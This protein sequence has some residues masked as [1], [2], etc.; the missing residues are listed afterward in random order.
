MQKFTIKNFPYS[1]FVYVMKDF[2]SGLELACIDYNIETGVARICCF[3][4]FM[5]G[6]I[7]DLYQLL[8]VATLK[9]H[10]SKSSLK[11]YFAKTLFVKP[12]SWKNCTATILNFINC[13]ISLDYLKFTKRRGSQDKEGIKE[14]ALLYKKYGFPVFSGSVEVKDVKY[15]LK[16]FIEMYNKLDVLSK[17]LTFIDNTVEIEE[18]KFDDNWEPPPPGCCTPTI[19]EVE[20]DI[21]DFSFVEHTEIVQVPIKKP[22]PMKPKGYPRAIKKVDKLLKDF[23]VELIRDREIHANLP[24]PT[25]ERSSKKNLR[26]TKALAN[27]ELAFKDLVV[28]RNRYIALH[29]AEKKL[30][31]ETNE[32]I[33]SPIQF[34]EEKVILEK[35]VWV[36]KK[37]MKVTEKMSD[38]LIRIRDM[39]IDQQ[40]K[41]RLSEEELDFTTPNKAIKNQPNKKA[42]RST[43]RDDIFL[44]KID[45][46][47]DFCCAKFANECV[48]NNVELR[49]LN[50]PSGFAQ[51]VINSVSYERFLRKNQF[52][53]RGMSSNDILKIIYLRIQTMGKNVNICNQLNTSKFCPTLKKKTHWTT[54][55]KYRGLNRV[56][57]R[58]IVHPI[59]TNADEID[60]Y[61]Q[62]HR[63]HM[64]KQQVE[65]ESTNEKFRELRSEMLVRL[66]DLPLKRGLRLLFQC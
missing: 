45:V 24:P 26:L 19:L 25:D 48:N 46:I 29:E 8:E 59:E 3:Y 10:Y 16:P 44:E 22:E 39:N 66:S 62:Y 61:P 36:P 47:N 20:E 11:N 40:N 5:M 65:I 9:L 43:C 35:K 30:I 49:K 50:V 7:P 4:L 52:R 64:K 37:V 56:L 55:K 21:G 23:E 38:Y 14:A 34:V 57:R 53:N 33:N 1:E 63:K 15:D 2:I 32:I 58:A 42:V 6:F 27:D 60:V 13:Q 41:I 31:I 28:K 54:G 18:F 17:E 12:K 51:K